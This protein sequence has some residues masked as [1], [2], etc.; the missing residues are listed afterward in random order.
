MLW[1]MGQAIMIEDIRDGRRALVSTSRTAL[2]YQAS[3]YTQ[4][5][6]W[7]AEAKESDDNE[8]GLVNAANIKRGKLLRYN[9]IDCVRT[10]QIH[11]CHIQE[12]NEDPADQPRIMRLYRHQLRLAHVASGMSLVGFLVDEKRRKSLSKELYTLALERSKELIK[13]LKPHCKVHLALTKKD[14]A[15][16]FHFR[17]TM[18]GGVNEN[19]LAALLFREC[20]RPGINGFN[21]EVPLDRDSRTETGKASVNKDALLILFT[22]SYLPESAKQIIRMC[23]KLDAP[24]KARSTYVESNKV[25]SRIGPDGRVHP[26]HNSCGTETGRF[27]CKDPNL[28][29]LPESQSEDSGSLRGDMPN[30]RD[31]YV[32]PRGMLLCHADFRAFEL[33]V[34]AEVTGDRLL[35]HGLDTGDVHSARARGFFGIPDDVPVPK[36]VRKNGKIGGLALQYHAG[37]ETAHMIILEQIQDARFEETEAMH[38]AFPNIHPGIAAWWTTS[39]DQA[40]TAGYN[41]T[42]IMN[43]RRYYPPDE[44]LKDTETS[45]YRV[46]GTAGDI[47]N[48]TMVGADEKDYKNSLDFKL[49]KY[50]PRARLIMHTYDSFDVEAPESQAEDVLKMMQETMAGPWKVGSTPRSYPSDGK[51]AKRWSEV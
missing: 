17:I 46:Q 38:D 14:K 44:R 23:W 20:A 36:A 9:A 39:L 25:L 32:A 4:C 18:S 24:L 5:S 2:A 35:R 33:E 10:A 28:Y 37:T 42:A 6:A 43:R 13:L 31:M 47:A 8:K 19:D 1:E 7:K 15:P 11:S 27:A 29:N 30:I 3:I 41:E 50:F 22:K 48:C 40:K 34:M 49:K 16:P 12:F 51:I 45:N 26:S 21:L